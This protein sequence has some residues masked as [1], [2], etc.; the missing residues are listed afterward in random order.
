[1]QNSEGN[2]VPSGE[3]RE[4]NEVDKFFDSENGMTITEIEA[5][6][7]EAKFVKKWATKNRGVTKNKAKGATAAVTSP[8]PGTG[9]A[10]PVGGDPDLFA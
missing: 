10:Q 5:G 1:M 7:I 3:T 4:S 6:S 9:V 8:K 2:W